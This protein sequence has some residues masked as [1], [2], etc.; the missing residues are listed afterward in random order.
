M[1]EATI[2]GRGEKDPD[3]VRRISF[4]ENANAETTTVTSTIVWHLRLHH[5]CVTS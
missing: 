4:A 2:P 1:I 3:I 5:K